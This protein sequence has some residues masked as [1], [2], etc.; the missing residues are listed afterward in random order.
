[1]VTKEQEVLD[2]IHVNL[3]AIR[4]TQGYK[5][6]Q[7]EVKISYLITNLYQDKC[8]ECK[9]ILEQKKK[10]AEN[11]IA[12]NVPNQNQNFLGKILGR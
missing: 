6:S 9:M 1:M 4:L 10:D 7:F 8:S 11:Q 3:H 12:G 2:T 5:P